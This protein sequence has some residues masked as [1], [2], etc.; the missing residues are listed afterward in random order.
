MEWNRNFKKGNF[1]IAKKMFS[2]LVTMVAIG[3]GHGN[4]Y[5]QFKCTYKMDSIKYISIKLVR[6]ALKMCTYADPKLAL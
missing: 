1:G 2:T 6:K 4:D 3:K 5:L